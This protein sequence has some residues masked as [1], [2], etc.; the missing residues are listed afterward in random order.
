MEK[1]AESLGSPEPAVRLILSILIGECLLPGIGYDVGQPRGLRPGH[2]CHSSRCRAQLSPLTWR[3]VRYRVRDVASGWGSAV[4]P[5]C[6]EQQRTCV[7]GSYWLVSKPR[8]NV[9]LA[10]SLVKFSVWKA[11]AAAEVRLGNRCGG[12]AARLVLR[13]VLLSD[14]DR[15]CLNVLFIIFP[16]VGPA[17]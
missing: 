10:A 13:E 16:L 11:P 6:L 1:L 17:I 7:A 8:L 5:C 12:A 9:C 2:R 14:T 3:S 4:S 15:T